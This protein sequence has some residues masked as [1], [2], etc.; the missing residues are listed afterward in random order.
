METQ[1]LQYLSAEALN[2]DWI[3]PRFNCRRSNYS[4]TFNPQT[5]TTNHGFRD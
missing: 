4:V 2:P 1:E 3:D 5:L